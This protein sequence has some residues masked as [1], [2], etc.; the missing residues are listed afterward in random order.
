MSKI[1]LK[2]HCERKCA[3]IRSFLVLYQSAR[4][5]LNCVVLWLSFKGYCM[6]KYYWG[7][8]GGGV[9]SIGLNIPYLVIPVT[10]IND[11]PT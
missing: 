11:F 2:S 4:R 3:G 8:G 6:D 5:F 1:S 7:A 9:P 10:K